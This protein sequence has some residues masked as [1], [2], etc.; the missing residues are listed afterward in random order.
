MKEVQDMASLT[1]TLSL[2]D[3][4]FEMPMKSLLTKMSI[5]GAIKTALLREEGTLS[6][7]LDI[8]KCMQS[9][10]AYGFRRCVKMV[11]MDLKSADSAVIESYS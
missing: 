1:G 10:D 3:T 6:R 5:D 7:F 11:G 9:G 4:I 8:A 2:A